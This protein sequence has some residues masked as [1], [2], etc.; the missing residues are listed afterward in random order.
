MDSAVL[1]LALAKMGL[2]PSSRSRWQLSDLRL[3]SAKMRQH[4]TGPAVCPWP[5]CLT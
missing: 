3:A 4:P 1:V 5:S 2:P